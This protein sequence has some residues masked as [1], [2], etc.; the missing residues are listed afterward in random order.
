MLIACCPSGFS[1]VITN[2]Q[3]AHFV[4]YLLEWTALAVGLM[5][6]RRIRRQNGG[7]PLTAPGSFAVM[8]SCLLGA[9]IGNKLAYLANDPRPWTDLIVHP[10]VWLQ[11]QSFVGALLGGWLGVETGKKISGITTRTGDDF[12]VPILTGLAIGRMGCFLA[13]LADG[14]CGLPTPLPWGVDFGDGIPRHPVQ[15][16]EC[17]LALAT[18]A[19][20]PLW[21][22]R[23]AAVP[24]L[25]FRVLVLGYLLWRV[26]V[27]FLKPV[28]HAYVEGLS[29]IQ[30]ICIVGAWV[31]FLGLLKDRLRRMPHE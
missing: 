13:G 19:A 7:P 4:H 6:Y 5:L 17:L 10:A 29:G 2:P 27:D 3:I 28:P 12:V 1:L 22:R 18:L 11:G 30:W 15:L 8:I 24:G 20:W 25:A 14:T 9:A 31:V 16:Y 23:L 26:L 21:R